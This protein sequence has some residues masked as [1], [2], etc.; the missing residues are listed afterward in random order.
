MSPFMHGLL[1]GF[2]L[3]VLACGVLV[4][5]LIARK[6]PGLTKH[7]RKLY[8]ELKEGVDALRS[9]REPDLADVGGIGDPPYYMYGVTG[10]ER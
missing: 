4:L 2:F 1:A 8:S 5:T 3:G 9:D 7:R 6:M 10:E